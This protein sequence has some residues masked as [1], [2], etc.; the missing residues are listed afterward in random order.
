MTAENFAYLREHVHRETGI[1]LDRPYTAEIRL[2]LLAES[3][4]LGST[5]LLCD[6]LRESEI[7]RHRLREQIPNHDTYFFR[8]AEMWEEI[9]QGMLPLR[10]WS[11]GCSTGQEPYSMAMLLLDRGIDRRAV[12]ILATDISINVLDHAAKGIY[13]EAEIRR[14]PP[15][16]VAK[17]C[18]CAGEFWQVREEVREM[19]R[20]ERQ[21]VRQIPRGM[22]PFDLILC[23]NVL[24]YF[25]RETRSRVLAQLRTCLSETGRLVLGRGEDQ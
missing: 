10:I 8:D 18:Q 23:R 16:L 2:Q 13:T 24:V 21:D 11:A 19:V 5:E 25:D 17:Y 6:R 4:G 12:D 14:I 1:L 20:F 15:P 22:G 3:L 9:R 7:L